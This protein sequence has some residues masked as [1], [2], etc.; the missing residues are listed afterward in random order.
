MF[1]LIEHPK[2]F[3]RI[4]ACLAQIQK[5]WPAGI[6]RWEV[7]FLNNIKRQVEENKELVESQQLKLADIFNR[8]YRPT[9]GED[10][11]S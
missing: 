9:K 4:T 6:A 1:E 11:E 8:I 5:K 3:E 10:Y 2:E 7:R